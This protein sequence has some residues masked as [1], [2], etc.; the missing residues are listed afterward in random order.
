VVPSGTGKGS[1]DIVRVIYSVLLFPVLLF[2][3]IFV[4]VIVTFWAEKKNTMVYRCVSE[5]AG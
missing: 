5:C 4:F 1:S 3:F 2:S